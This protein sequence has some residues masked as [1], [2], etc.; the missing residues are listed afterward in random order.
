MSVNQGQRLNH[1]LEVIVFTDEEGEMIG[2]QAMA[3]TAHVHDAE[4]YRRLEGTSIQ[5]CLQ[6]IG[7]DWEK[8]STAQ[9]T[10]Q[11]MAAYLEL[12]VEQGGGGW[13]QYS[14]K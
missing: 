14:A 4:A 1:P 3:G 5:T 8:L 10:A 11:D 6:R 9:R 12:H 13:K 2:S 7:G